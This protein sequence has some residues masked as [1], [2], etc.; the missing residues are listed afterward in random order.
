MVI[1]IKELRKKKNISQYKLAE[2]MGLN[3]SQI[4]KIEND[5]RN[6]KANELKKI[7]E[8]LEVPVTELF[9]SEEK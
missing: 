7:S 4:S 1:K 3:Q 5:K 6:L 8:I 9:F 2:L